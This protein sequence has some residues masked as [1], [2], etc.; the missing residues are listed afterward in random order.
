MF[1]ILN[2]IKKYWI[3][4][5]VVVAILVI[6]GVGYLTNTNRLNNWF[7]DNFQSQSSENDLSSAMLDSDI[8]EIKMLTAKV[9]ELQNKKN[10]L[11]K[12]LQFSPAN[13]IEKKLKLRYP[14]FL[15]NIILSPFYKIMSCE[16]ASPRKVLVYKGYG[17][18]SEP[19]ERGGELTFFEE[20]KDGSISFYGRV[21]DS[22]YLH[23]DLINIFKNRPCK[24]WYNQSPARD[25][26]A[27]ESGNS[28]SKISFESRT[29]N[30][31]ET[32]NKNIEDT[33]NLIRK[34]AQDDPGVPINIDATETLD[35]RETPGSLKNKVLDAREKIELLKYLDSKKPPTFSTDKY[36][37]E[38]TLD[39]T[40]CSSNFNKDSF[41]V[42]IPR[43]VAYGA[44]VSLYNIKRVDSEWKIYYDGRFY[45]LYAIDLYPGNWLLERSPL[46]S[47]DPKYIEYKDY[48]PRL[49][50]TDCE[51]LKTKAHPELDNIESGFP[52]NRNAFESVSEIKKRVLDELFNKDESINRNNIPIKD[53][54]FN[55]YINKII[56]IQKLI[57]DYHVNGYGQYNSRIYVNPMNKENL[58]V[59]IDGVNK[60]LDDI[61]NN[62]GTKEIYFPSLSPSEIEKN[63][64]RIEQEKQTIKANEEYKKYVQTTYSSLL[65]PYNEILELIKT[66]KQSASTKITVLRTELQQIQTQL[67]NNQSYTLQNNI[68]IDPTE[69]TKK[70]IQ[71]FIDEIDQVKK[72]NGIQ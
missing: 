67:N 21:Y 4:L 30:K 48:R 20:Q 59:L 24:D 42:A 34:I 28:F 35:L 44:E 36:N 18:S 19:S 11:S 23:E 53:D 29:D 12:S 71:G 40:I 50:S 32:D 22:F 43:M 6:V 65:T 5:V 46:D 55:E 13:G 72:D 69:K 8:P 9:K 39:L 57:Q 26:D 14:L 51:Y 31:P 64:E 38:N 62:I 27:E 49:Q 70:Y 33:V 41:I 63:K 3:K 68:T 16:D 37:R 47:N 58:D 25:S 54:Q 1:K 60:S 52:G 7:L 15:S 17:S 2:Q 56:L 61:L 66:D 10:D 45:P